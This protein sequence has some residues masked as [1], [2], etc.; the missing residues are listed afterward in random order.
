M[1]QPLEVIAR[2]IA[3]RL[4]ERLTDPARWVLTAKDVQEVV[5]D[6]YVDIPQE[7]LA[8]LARCFDLL[9]SWLKFAA[10]QGPLDSGGD[11]LVQ[12]TKNL[13]QK[14]RKAN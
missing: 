14:I 12:E 10:E 9:E 2:R 4:A 1:C 5:I 3:R 13:L 11:F 6:V 7:E 8:P